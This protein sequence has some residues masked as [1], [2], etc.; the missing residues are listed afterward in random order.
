MS[1]TMPAP[2]QPILSPD[3]V[4]DTPS[5]LVDETLMEQNIS[6]MQALANSFGAQL[7]PH[8]KTHKTPQIALRQISHGARGITCAKLGEAEVMVEAGVEDVLMAYPVV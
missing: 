2:A 4:L 5:M 3:V 7:R 6:E 1:M 8:I